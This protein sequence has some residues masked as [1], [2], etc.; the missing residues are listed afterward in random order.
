LNQFKRHFYNHPI[1]LIISALKPFSR[2]KPF[3]LFSAASAQS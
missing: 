3:P 2:P 1:L